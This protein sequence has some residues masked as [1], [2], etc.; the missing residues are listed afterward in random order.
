MPHLPFIFAAYAFTFAALGGLL[1][2]SL[3]RMRR[4]EQA[5]GDGER[6]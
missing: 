6:R 5:L 3:L 1:L 4:A 2:W